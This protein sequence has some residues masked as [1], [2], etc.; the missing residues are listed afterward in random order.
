MIQ[1]FSDVTQKDAHRQFQRW[2]RAHPTGYFINRKS[3][4]TYLLHTALCPHPGGTEWGVDT[5]ASLT[6]KRKICSNSIAEL[7]T[8]ASSCGLS[9]RPCQNCAPA[10]VASDYVAYHSAEVMGWDYRRATKSFHFYS[11]KAEKFLRRS[12]GCRVWVITGTR[13]GAHI[14]YKL[15]GTFVSSKVRREN[16]GFGILGVGTPFHPPLEVSGL[17]WLK[18]LRR[19]QNRFSYGFN[20][21]RSAKVVTEL[22]RLLERHGREPV[23]Q[24]DDDLHY[25]ARDYSRA[26]RQIKPAPHHKRMLQAHYHAPERTLTAKQMSRAM[27]YQGYR[28]AN[29]HYGEL[30]KLVAQALRCHLRGHLPLWALVTFT[31][32]H[33]EWHWTLRPEVAKAIEQ[34]GWTGDNATTLP[35]EV[36]VTSDIYEG[37]VQEVKVNKYERS[38]AAREECILHH[39][40]KC[41]VCGQMLADVYG[42]VAQ[43][44][45]H[46]HHLR[47][48]AETKRKYR[49]DPV[50]DLCPVCP[51]CHAIIH[52]K[53]PPYTIRQ[54]RNFIKAKR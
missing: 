12:I 5:G 36:L 28:A 46:A 42:E 41:A 3:G 32:P 39:G 34:L 22:Q 15:I 47:P 35:E 45:T 43:G 20:R 49:V 6:R 48:L 4:T 51:N 2:R 31:Q 44:F 29:R 26:L 17:P 50:H 54:V 9:L 11:H 52:L 19:E 16:D 25:T 53:S 1:E 18:E 23:P 8:W 40:C 30:G 24:P 14:R 37:A 38:S 27:G 10:P 21:I 13:V 7:Y 33:G